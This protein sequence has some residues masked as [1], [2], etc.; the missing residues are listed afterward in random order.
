MVCERVVVTDG[1]RVAVRVPD[2]E[3]VALALGVPVSDPDPD[4]DEEVVTLGV[5]ETL[6]DCVR[7]GVPEPDCVGLDEM[8]GDIDSLAVKL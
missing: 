1:D 2:P 6:G 5:L 3:R 8:L 4:G 7:L